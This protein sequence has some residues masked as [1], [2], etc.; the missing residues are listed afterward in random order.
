[1]VHS[2]VEQEAGAVPRLRQ[3]S[4]ERVVPLN[5]KR[6]EI[7]LR[8]VCILKQGWVA[9]QSVHSIT[10]T[11]LF[12]TTRYPCRIQLQRIE[13]QSGFRCSRQTKCNISQCL[14][15]GLSAQLRV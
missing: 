7:T 11:K 6:V 2:G 9:A 5:A 13:W 15:T 8:F 12:Q 3:V 10:F 14:V 4:V 1:M